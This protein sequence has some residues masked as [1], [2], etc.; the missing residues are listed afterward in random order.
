MDLREGLWFLDSAIRVNSRSFAEDHRLNT[1]KRYFLVLACCV[2]G[3]RTPHNP[4]FWCIPHIYSDFTTK[5]ALV[6][7]NSLH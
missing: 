2:L 7:F 3:G 5:Q 1:A 6:C 4:Q